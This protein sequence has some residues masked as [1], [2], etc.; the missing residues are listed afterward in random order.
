[1]PTLETLSI[2]KRIVLAVVLVLLVFGGWLIIDQFEGEAQDIHPS[3][4]DQRM[5]EIDRSALDDAY[6]DTMM[7]LFAVWTRDESGQPGRAIKGANQARRAYL[8]VRNDLDAR[9]K[10][11]KDRKQ[12]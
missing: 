12:Q 10:A 11:I 1:M 3:P 8:A 9:E 7:H 6:H 4:W 2:G 5:L